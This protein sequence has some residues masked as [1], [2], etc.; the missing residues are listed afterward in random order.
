MLE[1]SKSSRD[2]REKIAEQ[3]TEAEP[4]L[5]NLI[6]KTKELQAEVNKL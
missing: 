3:L 2:Y 4:K 1:S 6:T 5:S